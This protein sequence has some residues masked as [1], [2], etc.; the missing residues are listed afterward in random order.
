MVKGDNVLIAAA[1]ERT[2]VR[3]ELL[4]IPIKQA[5]F[6]LAWP[7]FIAGIL[8]NLATTVDMIMVGRLGAAAVASVGF[9]AMINWTLTALIL[10]LG[11]AVTAIV[12]RNFGGGQKKEAE[13]GLAQAMIMA[14]ALATGIVSIVFIL[15]PSIL[16]LFSVE[17]DVFSLSVPYLRIIAFSG[18]FS[19]GNGHLFYPGGGIKRGGRYPVSPAGYP[20]W[21]VRHPNS[22]RLAGEP[23]ISHG[24]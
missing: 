1:E 21:H 16:Q 4:K 18:F 8:E 13:F 9:C 24:N 17:A 22:R 12:A 6:R 15:A 14:L 20:Y 3:S 19:A 7:A 5:I 2:E 11:V 23:D 10:G